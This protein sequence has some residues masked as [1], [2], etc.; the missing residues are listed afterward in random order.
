MKKLASDPQL[1]L[2]SR[3]GMFP[4]VA[5]AS[6]A[7]LASGFAEMTQTVVRFIRE[8]HRPFIA[9]VY[10]TNPSPEDRRKPA[11][12]LVRWKSIREEQ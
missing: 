7:E 12:Q 1:P 6:L 4:L 2:N 5:K 8:D 3:V 10:R 9:K 11:G